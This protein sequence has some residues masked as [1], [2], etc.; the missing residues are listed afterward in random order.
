MNI[1]SNLLCVVLN[2]DVKL[3]KPN[4]Y[5]SFHH[6]SIV[7]LI[8]ETDMEYQQNTNTPL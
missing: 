1:V 8:V 3:V 2:N 4:N 7:T 6:N 5:I